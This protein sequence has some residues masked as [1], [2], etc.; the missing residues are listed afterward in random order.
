[1]SQWQTI[2]ARDLDLLDLK[3]KG[4]LDI[5]PCFFLWFN[6][7]VDYGVLFVYFF[8]GGTMELVVHD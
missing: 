6:D 2:I 8:H 1:M 5:L 3:R 4:G 7:Y